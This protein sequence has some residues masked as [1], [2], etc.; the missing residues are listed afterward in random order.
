LLVLRYGEVMDYHL[1]A[2][3]DAVHDAV[4]RY[5]EI[6]NRLDSEGGDWGELADVLTED[7]VYVDCAWGRTE[8]KAAIA[9]FL[10][11]AMVGIDFSNPVDFWAADGPRVMVKWRQRLPGERPD[12]R[13]YQQ[14]AVTTLLYAGGGLFRYVE[15]LLN[16]AH[17]VEDIVESAWQPGEGFN[18][19][20]ERPNRNFDPQP[21][22]LD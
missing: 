4:E 5:L 15:D 14:S 17:C 9:D 13:P 10:R 18:A 21:Q 7:A 11:E 6:R 22:E 1:P 2:S 19:P 16:V 8:G 3:D 12:G 20:P